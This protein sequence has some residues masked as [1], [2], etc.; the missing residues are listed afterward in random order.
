MDK[1]FIAVP[2]GLVRLALSEAE[3]LG[4][5]TKVEVEGLLAAEGQLTG[6]F[7][8]SGSLPEIQLTNLHLRTASRVLLRLGAFYA[9]DFETLKHN[10]GRLP[11]Q[12][13]L[14]SGQSLAVRAES[15]GSLLYHESAIERTVVE[16]VIQ[17]AGML[18]LSVSE[19]APG[20]VEPDQRILVRMLRNR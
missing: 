10:I 5:V 15:E 18:G 19:S 9:K 17:R 1:L 12:R 8:I 2:P 20:L 16:A 4:L 14:T 3:A 11:W 13:Y 6:G 7:E